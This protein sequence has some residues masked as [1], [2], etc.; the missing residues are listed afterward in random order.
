[1]YKD[2]EY[3]VKICIILHGFHEE[4]DNDKKIDL[5]FKNAFIFL[6]QTF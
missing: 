6:I 2:N 3:W 5:I 4:K 1:M